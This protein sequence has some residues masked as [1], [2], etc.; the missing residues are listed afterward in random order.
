MKPWL[1]ALAILIVSIL[2]NSSSFLN[3]MKLRSLKQ[4]QFYLYMKNIFLRS[5]I[6]IYWLNMIVYKWSTCWMMSWLIS[7]KHISSL[8]SQNLSSVPSVIYHVLWYQNILAH[9]LMTNALEKHESSFR[10]IPILSWF[11]MF[12]SNDV[13]NF[14]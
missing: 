13:I 14:L 3:A 2:S 5:L 7:L 4:W 12:V 9:S 8:R 10:T 1:G 6:W 11:S